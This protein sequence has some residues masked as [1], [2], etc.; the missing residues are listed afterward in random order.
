MKVTLKL[1]KKYGACRSAIREF[2]ELKLEGIEVYDLIEM[3]QEK[4]DHHSGYSRWLFEELR[5]TGKCISYYNH[6]GNI[7]SERNYK[8]GKLDGKYIEYFS[9]GQVC[10]ERN[11]RDSKIL[12]RTKDYG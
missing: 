8:K 2:E 9:N 5:L 10:S 7:C 3:I 11:Y 4:K 12:R 1:L 6:N